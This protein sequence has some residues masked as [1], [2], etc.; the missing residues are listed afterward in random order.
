[1]AS[2]APSNSGPNNIR[3]LFQLP[4]NPSPQDIA[5]LQ[6][7]VDQASQS[8]S[9]STHA[10]S[11]APPALTPLAD[12][13][14]SL[15]PQAPFTQSAPASTFANRQTVPHVATS[16][17][18]ASITPYRSARLL[19]DPVPSNPIA[20][21]PHH[22]AVP[23]QS[24][25]EPQYRTLPVEIPGADNAICTLGYPPFQRPSSFLGFQSMTS[26]AN[27][28][29]LS[30]A[31]THLPCRP[32]L[33]VRTQTQTQIRRGSARRGAAI[34]PPTLP[35]SGEELTDCYIRDEYGRPVSLKV[36]V[37]LYPPL[38][39]HASDYYAFR[40]YTNLF[41]NYIN[42]HGLLH[43]YELPLTT[44][45]M[46]I[47]KRVTSDMENGPF[48]YRFGH[49]QNHILAEEDLAL[50]LLGV[51]NRG[52]SRSNNQVHFKTQPI[53][54]GMTLEH[55]TTGASSERYAISGICIKYSRFNLHFA[56][57][58]EPVQACY[59]SEDGVTRRVHRCISARLWSRFPYDNQANAHEN[60]GAVTSGGESTDDEDGSRT[61]SRS[62]VGQSRIN[63]SQNAH[64]NSGISRQP[65]HD[66]ENEDV[67]TDVETPFMR[68]GVGIRRLSAIG[69]ASSCHRIRP[70]TPVADVQDF[71]RAPS[72]PP[73]LWL[74]EWVPPPT[75]DVLDLADLEATVFEATCGDDND[76]LKLTV[77]GPDV[78]ELSKLLIKHIETA[79]QADDFSK[80]LA[81]AREFKI[82]YTDNDG[83]ERLRSTGRGV[84]QEAVYVA[85]NTFRKNESEFFLPRA[86][87]YSSLAVT[88]SFS[89]SFISPAHL[90]KLAVL[91]ALSA[92]MLIYGMAP[93]PLS[94]V[95]V[96]YM[97][98]DC[99]FNSIHPGLLSEWLPELQQLLRCWIDGDHSL[100]L[101]H[102]REHFATYHDMQIS[103]LSHRDDAAHQ[104]LAAEMLHRAVIGPEGVSHPEF[105]A[106]LK[107]FKLHCVAGFEFP[108]IKTLM[109][110]G[111]EAL[112]NFAWSSQIKSFKD[113]EQH[114]RIS[115]PFPS[116]A[117][118]LQHA[119]SR[120]GQSFEQ[121]LH[122]FLKGS[123]VPCPALFESAK[124]HFSPIVDLSRIDELSFRS[125]MFAWAVTGSPSVD[126]TSQGLSIY[127]SPEAD[128]NYAPASHRDA[129]MHEGKLSFKTC[130]K[131]V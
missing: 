120:H 21:Q 60:S 12:A 99:D 46:D 2:P 78:A 130:F 56:I 117:L 114:L 26:Q 80:V 74:N 79:L 66:L 6:A 5:Q 86:G 107:G 103:C 44:A 90:Q 48:S 43:D 19:H 36:R 38:N 27:Q 41:D 69:P 106:F 65:V 112:L 116:V 40:F 4:A 123:G 71:S 63:E 122:N 82:I 25:R 13:F 34:P 104:A 88:H 7:Y 51:L 81:P 124:I 17:G 10:S 119:L 3:T 83:R 95:L 55:L 110:G 9:V 23:L 15:G 97:I 57:L 84:E 113:L 30:L 85:F 31:S 108:K 18:Q 105:Q 91:G 64:R 16:N 35:S 39:E 20:S 70:R 115:H 45:V 37:K 58:K 62:R 125:R 29:R 32:A 73:I 61:L 59:L 1:M 121:L 76:A 96:H 87:N 128:P 47:M 127:I 89:T 49:R 33:P 98:H 100:D 54:N 118:E 92:L 94:P 111:S 129:M 14:D 93:E 22:S 77:I 53:P 52:R 50:G 42:N 126:V 101:I 131:Q 28:Q 72:L 24:Q 102:F 8:S 67:S 68:L 109:E 11:T 75:S